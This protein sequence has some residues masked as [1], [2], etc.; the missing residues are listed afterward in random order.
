[1]DLRQMEYLV[2]LSEEQQFTRAAA[3]CGVSQSGLSSS[4]RSLE[5]EFGT[6]LF[7]RTT[8]RVTATDAGRAL[9]PFA[10][11]MLSQAAAARDAIVN[12]THDLSGRLRV[13]AEQCLGVIDVPPVLERFHRRYPQVDI[14]FVQAGS[15]ELATMVRN[16]D[17][18]VAFVA[19]T[20][21]LATMSAVELGR[22]PLVLLVP[23]SDPLASAGRIDWS[24][25]R[26]REFVD[27]RESWGVRTL[28]EA[29]FAAHG[30]ARRVSCTVD[31]VHTLLDL[32]HRGLGVALV[33]QHIAWK[34]Q[35]EGLVTLQLPAN[36]TPVWV[37]SA[38]AS[39]AAEPAASR[40]LEILN[41][42]AAECGLACADDNAIELTT[43]TPALP[44]TV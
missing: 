3:L 34:P 18:D 12:A 14:H 8:R 21:H 38:I 26:D 23:E 1:M 43:E 30:V 6:S 39:T 9:L 17:L 35:A 16:G 7:T 32:V 2:A 27:F 13:G 42:D 29:A 10:R 11:E 5:E 20:E 41:L 19:T 15:H 28:T 33:P 40:L 4:I 22:R 24:E 37:V 36:E 31:D 25:L 44:A